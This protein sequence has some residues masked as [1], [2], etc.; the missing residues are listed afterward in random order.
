MKKTFALACFAMLVPFGFAYADQGGFTNSG[1]SLAGGTNVANPPGTLTTASGT[2]TFLSTDGTTAIDGTLS[3]SSNVE[4]CSG[5]GKGGHVTCIFTFTGTF[6]GTLTVNGATQAINGSTYQRVTLSTSS[7][8]FGAV[9]VGT[10]SSART[11]TLTNRQN[12][13]LAMSNIAASAGFVV[14]TS[15]CGASVAAA[16]SCT[17]AVTC[18]PTAAG[19]VMG[20]LTFTDDAA[21]SP[22]VVSLSGTGQ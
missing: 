20:A 10:T 11:V 16:A 19:P 9:I 18:S 3:K 17:V 7:L 4:S 13:A 1:G 2:L 8:S 15:T 21:T 14:A 5:G 12:V 22:Q 6:S